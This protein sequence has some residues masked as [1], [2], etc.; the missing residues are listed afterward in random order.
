MK[1]LVDNQLPPALAAHLRGWSAESIHT[2]ECGLSKADDLAIWE[3]AIAGDY[4]VVSKDED[5]V[6][7]ANRQ[8]DRGRLV[9]IR[10]G[11][12]RNLELLAVFDRAK[13]AIVHSLEAGQ[14][15]IE[16]R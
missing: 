5:F 10:L 9:W 3:F 1:F 16:M 15:I 7:L 14:R 4:I 12:C 8:G 11:N 2:F 6:F 13:D